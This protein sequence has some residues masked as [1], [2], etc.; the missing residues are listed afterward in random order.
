MC[1]THHPGPIGRSHA[2]YAPRRHRARDR[3]GRPA[4]ARPAG[5]RRRYGV[6][7]R[8]QPGG[9]LGAVTG[10]RYRRRPGPAPQPG[11]GGPLLRDGRGGR[12]LPGHRIPHPR[13]DGRVLDA[14]GQAARRPVVQG[15]RHLAD[16]LALHQRLGLPADA[17]GHAR[18][19][20]DHPH[21]LRAGRAAGRAGRAAALLGEGDHPRAD[22]GRAL[23]ADEGLP[24]GRD[25]AEPDDVQPPGH[26][27]SGRP[28]PAV[29]GAG[30]PAGGQHR[31]ARLRGPGRLDV[32]PDRHRAGPRPP[33]TA[34]A[35]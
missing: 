27:R 12:Q 8:R 4:G 10:A 31:G 6:R 20:Q 16:L 15:R 25:R 24:V 34:G 7:G 13:R 28:E 2:S 30:H 19:G 9:G 21:R 1:D 11:G 3:P 33:R 26:R 14:A 35:T 22:R 23:R 29:P 17:A 18:R 5:L 32:D